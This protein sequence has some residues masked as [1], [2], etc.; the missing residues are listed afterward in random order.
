MRLGKRSAYGLFAVM[1]IAACAHGRPVLGREIAQRLAVPPDSLLKLLQRLVRGGVLLSER[2]RGGGFSL[3]RP[4]CELTLL[5]V[6]EAL[7]GPIRADAPWLGA[8]AVPMA[9]KLVIHRLLQQSAEQT[10]EA[11]A[12]IT[13]CQLLELF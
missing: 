6:I 10:R 8:I 5:E 1:H 3:A 11:L 7:E 13:M 12:R 2:G 9:P 4:P